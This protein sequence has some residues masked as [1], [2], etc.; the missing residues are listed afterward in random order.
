MLP[1]LL[2]L[3]GDPRHDTVGRP[4]KGVRLR[5]DPGPVPGSQGE[6]G[7]KTGEIL[8]RAAPEGLRNQMFGLYAFSGKATAFVGP[9][10]VGWLTYLFDSQRIG[11]S[12]VPVLL[13]VGG[14][15]MLKV[16]AP[17]D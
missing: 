2:R 12:I 7:P 6:S 17:E 1:L 9:F 8:A 14:L 11:M 16:P 4:V 13:T 5:I 3:P 10:L 15:L